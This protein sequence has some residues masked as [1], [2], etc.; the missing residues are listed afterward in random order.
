MQFSPLYCCPGFPTGPSRLLVASFI[1]KHFRRNPPYSLFPTV[2]TGR[3]QCIFCTH[4]MYLDTVRKL[5]D[6]SHRT[7]F[8]ISASIAAT[9]KIAFHIR[10]SPRIY[11]QRTK[12]PN[13]LACLVPRRHSETPQACFRSNRASQMA[14][15]LC[16]LRAPRCC[17]LIVT[18][19]CSSHTPIGN[20]N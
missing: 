16:P 3:I 17:H 20:L 7:L 12:N 1:L 14:L 8:A 15:L 5:G 19:D 6:L 2:C 4:H 10:N 9:R 13:T 11:L 18:R